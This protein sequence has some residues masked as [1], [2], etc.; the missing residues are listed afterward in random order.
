[1]RWNDAAK[2]KAPDHNIRVLC[3]RAEEHILGLEVTMHYAR[4]MDV[5]DDFEDRTDELSGSA[6]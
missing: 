5:C 2:V 1:V 6:K 4:R 3:G